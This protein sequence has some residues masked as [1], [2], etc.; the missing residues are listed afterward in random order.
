MIEK[1]ARAMTE[2]EWAAA[3]D[4]LHAEGERQMHER[5]RRADMTRIEAAD[6]EIQRRIEGDQK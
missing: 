4:R 6:R 1:H 5:D 2:S 3:L